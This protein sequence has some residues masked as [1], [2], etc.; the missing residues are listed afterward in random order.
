M[1]LTPLTSALAFAALPW[2]RRRAKVRARHVARIAM[3]AM[4]VPFIALA[5]GAA[6]SIWSALLHPPIVRG[7]A[8]HWLAIVVLVVGTLLWWRA[9]VDDYLRMEHP[10]AVAVSASIIGL[11][12]PVSVLGALWV[13]F[14]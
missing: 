14:G 10:W 7:H 2:S 12:A 6:G 1:G 4:C 8:L 3:H 5:F 13:I 11:L 9:A